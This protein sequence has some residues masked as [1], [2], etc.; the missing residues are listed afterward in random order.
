[1]PKNGR[2][3]GIAIIGVR[4]EGGGEKRKSTNDHPALSPRVG[5][6][7]KKEEGWLLEAT[8]RATF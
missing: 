7:A 1:M 4:S 5:M 2:A 3:S 6:T 8:N